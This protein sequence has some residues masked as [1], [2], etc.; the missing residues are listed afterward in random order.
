M[1][2]SQNPPTSDS[3][4]GNGDAIVTCFS[5][6]YMKQNNPNPEPQMP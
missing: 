1:S 6:D 4:V 5:E 2:F 3:D